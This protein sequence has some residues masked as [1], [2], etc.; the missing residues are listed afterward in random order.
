M[1]YLFLGPDRDAKD[2]KIAEIKAKY[3]T[4]DSALKLDYESFYG[5]KLDPDTLK[6]ALISLPA[7]SKQRLIL[8]RNVNKLDAHNKEIILDF[9]QGENS[10]AVVILDSDDGGGKN[11]FIAKVKLI[12]KVMN[13]GADTRKQNVF[14]MTRAIENQNPAVAL[15]I[16][17]ELIN[18][19]NP[20]LKIM[21]GM[22][23]F[24][25]DRKSRLSAGKFKEGLQVLQEADLNIKRS[26]IKPEYAVEV[27]VTKLSSLI[28][29]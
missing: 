16:L 6:K 23:W 7:V 10:H 15:K 29:C 8:I 25:G 17:N 9:I 2:R 26:R 27:A 13:F 19:G 14:D 11:S 18:D 4:D 1:I 21:G 24:W 22:V 28:A 20:P 3:L 5:V 12:A